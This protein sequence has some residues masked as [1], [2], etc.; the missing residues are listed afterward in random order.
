MTFTAA[1]KLACAERE[2]RL[3]K[4]VYRNRVL[5]GRMTQAFANREIAL[6]TSIRDD[7]SIQVQR[8]RLL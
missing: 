8:E 2:L 5:V 1:D 6:M 3:R 7:Y 4:N